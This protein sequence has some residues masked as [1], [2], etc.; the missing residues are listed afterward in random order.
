MRKFTI[1]GASALGVSL[2]GATLLMGPTGPVGH[3]AT[4]ASTTTDERGDDEANLGFDTPGYGLVLSE[5]SYW[6][7]DRGMN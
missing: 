7:R 2:L 5:N 4:V 1:L 6:E 3:P